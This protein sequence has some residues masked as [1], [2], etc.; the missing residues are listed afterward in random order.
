M[1]LAF[2]DKLYT[3]NFLDKIAK[4]ISEEEARILYQ[5]NLV[6]SESSDMALMELCKIK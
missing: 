5:S 6:E 2:E 3:N 4:N 1:N